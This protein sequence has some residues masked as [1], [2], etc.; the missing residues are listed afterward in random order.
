MAA[1]AGG[2]RGAAPPQRTAPASPP[3][4]AP[5]DAA[6]DDDSDDLQGGPQQQPGV[7][8]L[9][10]LRNPLERLEASL[11]ESVVRE[12]IPKRGDDFF[13]QNYTLIGLLGQGGY[14][15]VH[16][17]QRKGR[18]QQLAVKVT[19]KAHILALDQRHIDKL[20]H[21]AKTQ[22]CYEENREYITEKSKIADRL[23]V[24]VKAMSVAL[25]QQAWHDS[26]AIYQVL[27]HVGESMVSYVDRMRQAGRLPTAELGH[28]IAQQLFG[29]LWHLHWRLRIVHR[30]VKPDNIVLTP[31]PSGGGGCGIR[32]HLIDFGIAKSI[33]EP[34]D[35]SD[36]ARVTREE[37]EKWFKQTMSMTPACTPQYAP[38]DVVD[39]HDSYGSRITTVEQAIRTDIWGAGLT[40]AC[41]LSGQMFSRLD[42]RDRDGRREDRNRLNTAMARVPERSQFLC[43]VIK[44]CLHED[45][46][47][48]PVYT[49]CGYFL[50]PVG[51]LVDR[52]NAL[53]LAASCL[54]RRRSDAVADAVLGEAAGLLDE[55]NSTLGLLLPI[56]ELLTDCSSE[57]Y[58]VLWE[59]VLRLCPRVR[60]RAEAAPDRGEELQR[61][62]QA[63][64]GARGSSRAD[65]AGRLAELFPRSKPAVIRVK[66]LPERGYER[67][68]K[69]LNELWPLEVLCGLHRQQRKHDELVAGCR[70]PEVRITPY[71]A[72]PQSPASAPGGFVYR[73][74]RCGVSLPPGYACSQC[75]TGVVSTAV[76]PALPQPPQPLQQPRPP[77]T[78]PAH[79]APPQPPQQQ[80][81]WP[82]SPP[83]QQAQ[84]PQTQPQ[85]PQQPLR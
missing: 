83:P 44:A 68:D 51:A 35:D 18:Q 84:A 8:D 39:Q 55:G 63:W 17:C 31:E 85:P 71:Q 36:G 47:Q 13:E 12:H 19:Y 41:F 4:A 3:A 10:P 61:C 9:E 50:A 60:E 70:P 25:C 11:G 23:L 22:D 57:L 53:L 62:W 24:E 32:L 29:A 7:D 38:L 26:E 20:A 48:R 67:Q 82:Q 72:D 65:A 45:P 79:A 69:C 6:D 21:A 30:D 2:G 5:R 66:V 81:Q 58:G 74:D 76:R 42:S 37:I 59:H 28:G 14:S 80:Q 75:S 77:Q 46:E 73:C 52:R 15:Q 16:A 56:D 27:E 34:R 78:H 40:L 33:G 43:N 54:Q 64:A 1:P 49:A